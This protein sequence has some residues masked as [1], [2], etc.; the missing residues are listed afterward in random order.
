MATRLALFLL[1]WLLLISSACFRFVKSPVVNSTVVDCGY[2]LSNRANVQA[3][4]SV[5]RPDDLLYGSAELTV[6]WRSIE[7]PSD[8]RFGSDELY[9]I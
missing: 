9:R 4:W 8:E 2:D 6:V 7:P 1:Q 5:D 3:E